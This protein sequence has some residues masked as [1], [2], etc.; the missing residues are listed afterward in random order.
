MGQI[1]TLSRLSLRI[2]TAGWIFIHTQSHE[3]KKTSGKEIRRTPDL[4]LR[5]VGFN[6]GQVQ[7][8]RFVIVMVRSNSF[9]QLD[10]VK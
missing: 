6:L 2:V 9:G 8:L 10:S 7:L 4:K 1:Y 3:R 5:F